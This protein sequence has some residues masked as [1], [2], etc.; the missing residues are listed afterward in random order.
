M[1]PWWDD[2]SK[3]HVKDYAALIAKAKEQYEKPGEFRTDKPEF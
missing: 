3:S 2:S 1:S